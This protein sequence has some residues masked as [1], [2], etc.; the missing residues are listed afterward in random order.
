VLSNEQL[1][2]QVRAELHAGMEVLRPSQE[3]LEAIEALTP[4]N[5]RLPDGSRVRPDPG[6]G[7]QTAR[8]RA[9]GA[10]A[11]VS[12]HR[13]DRDQRR[14]RG[15]VRGLGAAVPVLA[16]VIVVVV[17]AAVVLTSVRHHPGSTRVGPAVAARNGK[18]AFIAF[19]GGGYPPRGGYPPTRSEHGVMWAFDA[20]GVTNP[21]GSGRQNVG[22]YRCAAPRSA[23]GVYS[24]AWST[25]GTKIA[26]LAG[27]P[28]GLGAP[29]SLALYLVDANGNNPRELASCGDCAGL[30]ADS[31]IA[32]S[33]DG[34][35]I[36]LTRQTGLAQDLWLVNVKTGA[37]S[38]LTDCASPKACAD[39]SAEWSPGGQAI[40]FS[41]WVKGQAESIYTMR[42]DGTHLKL[43]AA[44]AGAQDPQWSPDGRKIAFQANNGI[45]TVNA[46]GTQLTRIAAAGG[47]AGEPA[48]SPDGNEL[49]YVK[50]SPTPG[51]VE[52]TQLWT[53][54]A[55]GSDNRRIYQI[56]PGGRWPLPFWSPDG[57]Q[58]AVAP[59]FGVFVMNANGTGARLVGESANQVAWQPIPPTRR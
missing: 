51:G 10:V 30:N 43:I 40:V 41:R 55:N 4:D 39:A 13:G 6:A 7:P 29:T 26:Y 46:D 25:D 36:A 57:K 16:G 2:E 35:R 31:S 48:W 52:V 14:W 47:L 54:N 27:H 33:P 34:S 38:R 32:W 18:V 11:H 19:G 9:L 23:C 59:N 1:I 22:T 37:L 28:P 58:I 24:F 53:I 45:Y 5:G 17:V 21:D 15:R 8:A 42:P 44:G 3:L 49:L 50:S 20:V 12:V 56:S